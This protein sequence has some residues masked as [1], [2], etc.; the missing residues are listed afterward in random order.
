MGLSLTRRAA[1]GL[2]FIT[3]LLSLTLLLLALFLPYDH[4]WRLRALFELREA[5][6][7]FAKPITEQTWFFKRAK[8]PLDFN[9][10]VGLVIKTSYGRGERVVAQLQAM[11]YTGVED[12][13]IVVG[14][15]E[16]QLELV[17]HQIQVVDVVGSMLEEGS[18]GDIGD[19][20][21]VAKYHELQEAI[22]IG[23]DEEAKKLSE[24]YGWHLDAM[25]SIPGLELANKRAPFKKW[26]IIIDD[27]TL[28]LKASLEKLLARLDPHKDQYLGSVMTDGGV[29][30]MRFAYGKAAIIISQH[31]L[32]RLFDR[33][34]IVLG[35]K[36]NSLRESPGDQVIAAALMKIGVYIDDRFTPFFNDVQP[37][38]TRVNGDNFCLPLVNF[39]GFG[40]VDN[41][42]A[43]GKILQEHG[44]HKM[45]FN[46]AIWTIFHEPDIAAFKDHPVRPD[47]DHVGRMGTVRILQS[48]IL[49]ST[50]SYENVESA[51]DCVSKCDRDWEKCLAWTWIEETR[52]CRLASFVIVGDEVA[53]RFSGLHFPRAKEVG[54]RCA[55]IMRKAGCFEQGADCGI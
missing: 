53:G 11:G 22:G 24:S 19:T 5:S 15:I 44:Q 36:R 50:A 27:D 42:I 18:I 31:S 39:H 29:F 45:L 13:I 34:D 52:E 25:K 6:S 47:H 30:G 26:W 16:E 2:L 7:H 14:D 37:K 48:E 41:L 12:G 38:Y 4:A 40:S 8:H 43:T 32:T 23:Q 54:D 20:P 9:V 49:D 21:R 17:G 55:Q 35:A 10:D 1:R 51:L 28:L 3:F 46:G 33:P